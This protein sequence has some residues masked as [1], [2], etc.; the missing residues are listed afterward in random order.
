MPKGSF[1]VRE[2]NWLSLQ[3][4]EI[5]TCP[6][7]HGI[8]SSDQIGQKQPTNKPKALAELLAYLKNH[9]LK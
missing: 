3:P 6:A 7:C 1:V 5:R 4:G 2:R 8:N 9:G